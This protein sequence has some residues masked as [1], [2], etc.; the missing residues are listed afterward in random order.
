MNHL[1]H[2]LS[3]ADISIFSSETS[4]F[5]Y[6]RKYKHRLHFGKQFGIPLTFFESFDKFF[7]INAVTILMMSAKFATPGLL[8]IKIFQN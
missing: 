7:L 2:L 5:C 4:K 1:T 3:S 6:I 8:K